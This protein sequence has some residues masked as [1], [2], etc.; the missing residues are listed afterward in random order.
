VRVERAGAR[1]GLE[2]VGPAL[3]HSARPVERA[4]QRPAEVRVRQAPRLDRLDQH[5]R[6]EEP[7]LVG[8][9][10]ADGEEAEGVRLEPFAPV[11][12]DLECGG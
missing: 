7:V 1:D 9:L 10:S 5:L 8:R 2:R 3:G 6:G 4:G 11:E 12:H